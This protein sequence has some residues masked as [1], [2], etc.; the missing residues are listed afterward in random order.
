M[1][2]SDVYTATS[3]KHPR[4]RRHDTQGRISVRRVVLDKATCIASYLPFGALE[5]CMP[6]Q[7]NSEKAVFIH[8]AVFDTMSTV[9]G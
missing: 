8:Y 2:E 7:S 5:W 3:S 1:N 4:F 6:R 9:S